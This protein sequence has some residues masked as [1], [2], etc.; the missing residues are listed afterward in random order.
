MGIEKRKFPRVKVDLEIGYEFVNWKDRNL[1]KMI[2][3]TFIKIFDISAGGIGLYNLPN[4]SEKLLKKLEK[5]KKKIRLAIYLYKDKPPLITFARLI[6]SNYKKEDK[7]IERYGFVFLDVSTS[8]FEEVKSY[9]DKHLN[10][11]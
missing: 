3:P 2:N 8:F 9:V 4:L 7:I 1:N 10:Q 5:G 11:K 6:W